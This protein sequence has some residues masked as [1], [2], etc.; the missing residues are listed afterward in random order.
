MEFRRFQQEVGHTGHFG[1]LFIALGLAIALGGVALL[2]LALSGAWIG[3]GGSSSGDASLAGVLF[4]LEGVGF[5]FFG[6]IALMAGWAR[7]HPEA[8]A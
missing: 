5:A 8:D 4:I 2:Y 1:E 3:P 7:H 6:I